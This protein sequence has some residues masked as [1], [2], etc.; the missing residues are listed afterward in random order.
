MPELLTNAPWDIFQAFGSYAVAIQQY[1]TDCHYI[2]NKSVMRHR[3]MNIINDDEMWSVHLCDIHV[4]CGEKSWQP[5]SDLLLQRDS[6]P[7]PVERK[8]PWTRVLPLV[9][10]IQSEV[11]DPPLQLTSE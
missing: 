9:F 3:K 8:F 10:Q 5:K 11:I 2:F 1:A 7:G 4:D 6:H